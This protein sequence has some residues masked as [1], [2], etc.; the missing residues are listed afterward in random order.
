[1]DLNAA[2]GQLGGFARTM[3]AIIR[4]RDAAAKIGSLDGAIAE[5]ESLLQRL[6]EQAVFADKTLVA[7]GEKISAAQQARDANVAETK[8]FVDRANAEAA[9]VINAA[10]AE[11]AKVASASNDAMKR[12]HEKVE[13][14]IVSLEMLERAIT[15]KA[16]E[17]SDVY[18]HLSTDTLIQI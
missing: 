10:H 8:R 7:I 4:L 16:R 18:R 6:S 13:G 15:E 9:G 2:V 5:R 17:L 11:A 1:M 12:L 14:A 3:E